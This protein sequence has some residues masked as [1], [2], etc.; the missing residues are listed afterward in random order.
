MFLLHQVLE[1]VNTILMADIQ[2]VENNCSQASIFLKSLGGFKL[3]VREECLNS[4]LTTVGVL[5]ELEF[6]EFFE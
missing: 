6:F 1:T 2:N 5:F 3:W 4:F